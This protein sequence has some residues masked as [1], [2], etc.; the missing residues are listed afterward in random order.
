[1]YGGRRPNQGRGTANQTDARKASDYQ[2][3]GTSWPPQEKV[4]IWPPFFEYQYNNNVFCAKKRV[5]HACCL[6]NVYA[7]GL[8]IPI[9]G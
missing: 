4:F 5:G 7:P 8:E 6:Y 9:S 1:M 3:T 2:I